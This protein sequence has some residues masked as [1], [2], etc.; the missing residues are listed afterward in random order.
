MSLFLRINRCLSCVRIDRLQ[1]ILDISIPSQNASFVS[2]SFLLLVFFQTTT[3]PHETPSIHRMAQYQSIPAVTHPANAAEPEEEDIVKTSIHVRRRVTG[4][5]LLLL[6]VAVGVVATTTTPTTSRSGKS[7]LVG[8]T[9]VSSPPP[10]DATAALLRATTTTTVASAGGGDECCAPATGTWNGLSSST[11][12]DDSNSPFEV[13]YYYA[14]C[15]IPQLSDPNPVS[16]CYCWSKSFWNGDDWASCPPSGGGGWQVYDVTEMLKTHQTSF[17]G[18]TP[19]Q[20]FA[21]SVK[22]C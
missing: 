14:G 5:V 2:L 8:T 17:C 16:D 9:P 15:T 18:N 6:C 11:N 20:E 1:Y 13:C 12:D 21:G 10:A 3:K 4:A 19:C 22:T 7:V